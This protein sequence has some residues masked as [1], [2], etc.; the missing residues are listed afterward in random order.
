MRVAYT[1]TDVQH[2]RHQALDRRKRALYLGSRAGL[3][4][5]RL[6]RQAVPARALVYRQ[7]IDAANRNLLMKARCFRP[8]H[9]PLIARTPKNE[10]AF[11]LQ[12][13]VNIGHGVPPRRKAQAHFISTLNVCGARSK[14]LCHHSG[15]P[16][17]ASIRMSRKGVTGDVHSGVT[18]TAYTCSLL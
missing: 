17:N 10:R 11:A 12:P 6:C 18:K 15:R 3:E 16:V 5:L 14:Q 8:F 13:H 7:A 2:Y 1:V 4:F 9:R